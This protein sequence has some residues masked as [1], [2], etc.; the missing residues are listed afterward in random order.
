[1]LM[2]GKK[3]TAYGK[4][5]QALLFHAGLGY[6][7]NVGG[8]KG[9]IF[10]LGAT[11]GAYGVNLRIHRFK[12]DEPEVKFRGYIPEWEEYDI[13]YQLSK[14][15]RVRALTLDG[16]YL[17]NGKRFS[18]AAAY[19]QSVVQKR[20][21]GSLMAGAMYY[22]STVAYD[23]GRDA[24][25]IMYMNDIGRMKQYQLSLGGGYAYNLV[26]CKGLLVSAM[27]M[28]MLTAYNRLDVW[29]YNSHLREEEIRVHSDPQAVYEDLSGLT[30]DEIT[31]LYLTI[32]PLEGHEKSVI[33]SRVKPVVDARLSLTYNLGNWFINANAVLNRFG[34]RHDRNKGSL[35]GWQV[36]ASVGLR[37]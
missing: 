1:M 13:P 11:G 9:S 34:Y 8:D 5:Q 21:A 14:P 28:V 6:S 33:H 24:E 23:E 27:G 25:F 20:S 31:D 18:Y 4:A 12:T 22:H 36:N 30:E 29:R 26:P 37:L 15:I 2:R 19:D 16:Y 35:T 17:F 3:W 10:R 7:K 32:W